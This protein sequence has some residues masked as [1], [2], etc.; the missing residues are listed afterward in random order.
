MIILVPYGGLINRMRVISAGYQYSKIKH[1]KLIVLWERNHEINCRFEILFQK[2]PGLNIIQSS[3][4]ILWYKKIIFSIL[5]NKTPFYK[6]VTRDNFSNKQYNK[7][8]LNTCHQ[9][10]G[11]YNDLCMF[12]PHL[13]FIEEASK[14]IS[15]N[16]IGVHIRRT[17]HII[18]IENSPLSQFERAIEKEIIN[19]SNVKFYLSTDDIKVENELIEKFKER[20]ITRKKIFNRNNSEGIKDALIDFIAL[21]LSKR[22]Y[23]SYLSSFGEFA[24]IYGKKQFII[25][26]K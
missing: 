14:Y 21:S 15:E 16:T 25:I 2:I 4:L 11:N 6:E 9:F 23:G 3:N 18:A 19:D 1:E 24:A 5:K 26:K 7:Y 8:Y 10:F 17:D 13:V 12:K 22:I 20:I